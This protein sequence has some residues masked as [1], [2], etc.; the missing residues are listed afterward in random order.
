MKEILN[1]GKFINTKSIISSKIVTSK[2][3]G[4]IWLILETGEK[5]KV[6]M[7]EV[8]SKEQGEQILKELFND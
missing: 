1:S 2:E 8:E 4:K 7:H 5:D 3:N 6:I